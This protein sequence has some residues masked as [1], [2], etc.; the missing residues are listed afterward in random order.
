MS[1]L[2]GRGHKSKHFN[3]KIS[4][5]L[6]KSIW[7]PFENCF[8]HANDSI[9][10]SIF[11]VKACS[12]RK[13]LKSLFKSQVWNVQEFCV[14][15]LHFSQMLRFLQFMT[16]HLPFS[17]IVSCFEANVRLNS[18]LNRCKTIIFLPSLQSFMEHFQRVYASKTTHQQ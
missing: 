7:L 17:L 1:L 8:F 10:N 6:A 15:R 11:N 18:L 12:A 16:L 9:L 5:F 13:T 4:D 2:M 3:A 14:M